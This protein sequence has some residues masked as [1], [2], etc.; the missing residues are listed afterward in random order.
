M[1]QFGIGKPGEEQAMLLIVSVLST[2][3]ISFGS[4][5]TTG[6]ALNYVD[7]GEATYAQSYT[8]ESITTLYPSVTLVE[9]KLSIYPYHEAISRLESLVIVV[10]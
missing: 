4:F 10:E 7:K 5:H 1:R 3:N 2:D 8:K 6:A 9:D